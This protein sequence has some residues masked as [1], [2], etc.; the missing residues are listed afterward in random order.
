MNF[1]SERYLARLK[2]LSTDLKIWTDEESD[3]FVYL[4]RKV[5]QALEQLVSSIIADRFPSYTYAYDFRL[6]HSNSRF[7]FRIG[8]LLRLE[9]CSPT[10]VVSVSLTILREED[11]EDLIVKAIKEAC[12]ERLSIYLYLNA[13]FKA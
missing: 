12:S 9:S 10:D 8:D 3:E 2:H 5:T 7:T 11:K 6:F 1:L 13:F 4:D